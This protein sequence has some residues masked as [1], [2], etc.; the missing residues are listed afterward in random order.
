[1]SSLLKKIIAHKHEEVAHRRRR[2]S[3]GELRSRCQD[4]PPCRNFAG[5]LRRRVEGGHW[6]V[7]AEIKRASPSQGKIRADLDPATLAAEYAAAGATC[8]SV[9]TDRAFFEG[10]D[11]D[12]EAARQA[13]ELPVLRKDFIIDPYQL[14]ESR[15][16][17]AD[18]VL[19]IV[20]ALEA[21]GLLAE[22]A[23]QAAELGLDTLV[24]VHDERELQQAL[25]LRAGLLGINNRN[26]HT[27]QT[28]LDTTLR[29]SGQ[30]PQDWL[31]IS[32]SGIRTPDDLRRLAA[33]GV[34]ALLV[35]ESLLRQ[36]QPGA[37][38]EA[39]LMTGTD[40]A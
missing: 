13:V 18:C 31:T 23:R 14:H 1:M 39:L 12:L 6:G 21:G 3:L 26:L 17:G 30:V 19:L 11:L 4:A 36:P 7:I 29:L 10:A 15:L 34:H 8:L 16:M 25:E 27:F 28:S 38:L 37:A 24:E 22:L 40:P 2:R 33:Q 32:E 20:A 9:L 5:T 35:G